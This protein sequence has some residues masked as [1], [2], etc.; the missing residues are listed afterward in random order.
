MKKGILID[1]EKQIFKANGENIG[2][3]EELI[4]TFKNG[5]WEVKTIK[6]FSFN[7]YNLRDIKND[8]R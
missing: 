2:N 4:I 1:T 7:N 8:N 3:A 5:K 6:N